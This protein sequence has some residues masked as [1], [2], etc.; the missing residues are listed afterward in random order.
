MREVA[1]RLAASASAAMVAAV[2]EAA[3]ETGV[4]RVRAQL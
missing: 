4:V 2:R 1:A 3:E